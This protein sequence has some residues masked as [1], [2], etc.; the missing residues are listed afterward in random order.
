MCQ[1]DHQIQSDSYLAKSCCKVT[2]GP[3]DAQKILA[4]Y[5]THE[6]ENRIALRIFLNE[7]H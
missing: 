2:D 7:L 4:I 5:E 3:F 6:L 1:K